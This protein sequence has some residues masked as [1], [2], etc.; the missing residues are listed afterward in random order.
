MPGD[1]DE[2]GEGVLVLHIP[3]GDLIVPA[4]P[5]DGDEGGEGVLLLHI[6]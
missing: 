1:G 2:G 5:G 6:P 4:V 3:E